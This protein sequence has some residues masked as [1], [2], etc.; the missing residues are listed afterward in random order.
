MAD[1][2]AGG[3]LLLPPGQV[4]SQSKAGTCSPVSPDSALRTDMM[5]AAIAVNVG[6]QIWTRTQRKPMC[7]GSS[8]PI[9]ASVGHVALLHVYYTSS[10]S[11][12]HTSS[13][14]HGQ[15]CDPMEICSLGP[16]TC[17]AFMM[18][19]L[20]V[21]SCISFAASVQPALPMTAAPVLRIG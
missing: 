1:K 12:V 2:A 14:T 11:S 16:G 20:T 9:K 13:R 17:L 8:K 21:F 18:G 3:M 6:A 5:T 15:R 10:L 7:D 19:F 4:A